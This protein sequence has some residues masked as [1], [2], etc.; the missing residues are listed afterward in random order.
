MC[1]AEN[2]NLTHISLASHFWDIGKQLRP[3]SEN[4]ASNQDVHCLLTGISIQNMIKMEK[5]Q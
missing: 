1:D 4:A 3:K 5:V 2:D